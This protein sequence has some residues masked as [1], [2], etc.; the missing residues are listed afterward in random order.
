MSIRDKHLPRERAA[1]LS[2]T[3]QSIVNRRGRS[4]K[5]N[6]DNRSAI[7]L[8]LSFRR[9]G[10]FI[11]RRPCWLIAALDCLQRSFAGGADHPINMKA[12]RGTLILILGI[13]SVTICGP[14]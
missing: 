12:H 7:S 14:A 9:C 5:A 1:L 8:H 4:S 2:N 10:E 3:Q 13:L 11:T 6:P